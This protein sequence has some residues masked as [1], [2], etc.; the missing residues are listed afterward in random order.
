MLGTTGATSTTSDAS[1][2]APVGLIDPS[3]SRGSRLSPREIQA[4]LRMGRTP[5]AVA[6]QAGVEE[7]WVQ[8][9]LPPIEAER[10]RIIA[11]ARSARIDKA[12]KGVSADT[13]GDAVDRH[14]AAK[15]A[16]DVDWS[17]T[18]RDGH[19]YW[20]VAVRYRSRGK[21]RRARWRFDPD[22]REIE[23]EDVASG[24]LA[25][26]PRPGTR[27]VASRTTSSSKRGGAKKKATTRKATKKTAAKSSTAKKTAAKNSAAKKT[28]PAEPQPP[29][30]SGGGNHTTAPS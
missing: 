18:R 24:D 10:A 5:A 29:A 4:L 13:L 14:L 3:P 25:W 2:P 8:R 12:R 15:K 30:D 7:S 20:M 23:P 6:K 16:E 21:A 22:T 11:A 1:V 28:A 17:A 19:P 9:W 27:D 26:T